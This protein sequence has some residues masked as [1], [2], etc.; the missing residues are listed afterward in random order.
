M[1][2]IGNPKV[3]PLD[4]A[5]FRDLVPEAG[6]FRVEEA[7]PPE[8]IEGASG[9]LQRL[10]DLPVQ[11][12]WICFTDRVE[13]LDTGESVQGLE[14]IPL[15]GELVVSE[16]ESFHLKHLGDGRWRLYHLRRV[17]ETG[18]FGSTRSFFLDGDPTRRL[19]YEVGWDLVPD[20]F[21]E[22]VLRPRRARF[23]GFEPADEE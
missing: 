14:G 4:L 20:A 1:S 17:N 19:T 21:G 23:A 3:E 13:L 18:A 2:A 6:S 5:P 7:A 16:T 8:L 22:L 10:R 12:G 11:Q 15:D 9:A